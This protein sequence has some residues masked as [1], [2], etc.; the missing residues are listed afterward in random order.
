MVISETEQGSEVFGR[1]DFCD[2]RLIIS[3]AQYI[4][5]GE[6]TI[7]TLLKCLGKRTLCDENCPQWTI[8]MLVERSITG[9][10]GTDL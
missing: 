7:L 2:F 4:K 6:R 1:I 8:G 3:D 10:S 9:E 5:I